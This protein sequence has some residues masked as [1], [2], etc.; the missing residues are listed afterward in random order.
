MEIDVEVVASSWG[1]KK[2]DRLIEELCPSTIPTAPTTT[3]TN[4]IP[5]NISKIDFHWFSFTVELFILIHPI[6]LPFLPYSINKKQ[7]TGCNN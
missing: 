2:K 5:I 4:K 1:P 7:Y 3:I 6:H